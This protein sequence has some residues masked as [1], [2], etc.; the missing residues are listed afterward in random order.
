MSD[1]GSYS[2]LKTGKRVSLKEYGEWRGC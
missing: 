1:F 2:L